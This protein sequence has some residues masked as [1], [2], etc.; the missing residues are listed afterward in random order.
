M[1][2]EVERI[3]KT[4]ENTKRIIGDRVVS[5]KDV[6][7]DYALE[8]ETEAHED[9]RELLVQDRRLKNLTVEKI[10]YQKH[11]IIN[12]IRSLDASSAPI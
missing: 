8:V 2:V 7:F 10:K 5:N 4:I 3:L 12:F 6:E 1:E 11:P 9:S